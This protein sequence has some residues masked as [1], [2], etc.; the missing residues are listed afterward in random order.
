[1]TFDYSVDFSTINFRKQP[2]LYRI[3][4]GEQ[5]V[6]LVE[7]Y[8]VRYCRTGNS[9]GLRRLVFQPANLQNVSRV[10]LKRRFR[11][12]GHGSQISADGLH[13]VTKIRQS[14]VKAVSTP[15]TLKTTAPRRRARE[16]T[17]G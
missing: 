10:S 11:G 3:R 7:P 5:G 8:K 2:E 16:S 4:K 14:S 12:N 9:K 13:Q 17:I 1:M 15:R 6:L